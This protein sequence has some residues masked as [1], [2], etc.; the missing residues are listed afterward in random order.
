MKT[1]LKTAPTLLPI[2]LAILLAVL[3]LNACAPKNAPRHNPAPSKLDLS[4]ADLLCEQIFEAYDTDKDGK[5]SSDE[6]AHGV[7]ITFHQLD[8]N[9]DLQ[10]DASE[11]GDSWD[12]EAMA[13]DIDGDGRLT[14]SEILHHQSKSFKKRDVDGCGC[15][16]E[17]DVRTWV[18]HKLAERQGC[19]PDGTPLNLSK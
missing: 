5:I 2:F 4:D 7:I 11:L 10:L 18:I 13:V 3:T 1:A 19:H 16:T 14:L 15:L 6:Y 17:E 9:G 8:K 12:T